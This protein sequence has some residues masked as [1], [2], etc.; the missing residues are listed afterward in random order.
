MGSFNTFFNLFVKRGLLLV[1]NLP[2]TESALDMI[3][4][5]SGMETSDEVSGEDITL[6]SLLLKERFPNF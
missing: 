3:F 4:S 5:T 6:L 2:T 1:E